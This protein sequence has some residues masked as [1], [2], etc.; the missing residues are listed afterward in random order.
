[1]EQ[2][3]AMLEADSSSSS[4][5]DSSSSDSSDSSDNDSVADHHRRPTTHRRRSPSLSRHQHTMVHTRLHT[6]LQCTLPPLEPELEQQLK[7]KLCLRV[8]HPLWLLQPQ[9][10]GKRITL[11]RS[12]RQPPRGL[13]MAPNIPNLKLLLRQTPGTAGV[14]L[15]LMM[16]YYSYTS[17]IS[18]F[19]STLFIDIQTWRSRL[20]WCGWHDSSPLSVWFFLFLSYVSNRNLSKIE[21][22]GGCWVKEHLAKS[23]RPSTLK[24]IPGRPLRLFVLFQN[25]G[26]QAELKYGCQCLGRSKPYPH[27]LKRS[28][29]MS[30]TCRIISQDV[31]R[32]CMTRRDEMKMYVV[33]EGTGYG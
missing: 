12:V 7:L 18:L 15:L 28:L 17:L 29:L 24:P 23:S 33:E 32:P 1:M 11:K 13:Y 25:I 20:L 21:L 27:A 2:R 9:R 5:S 22:S 19:D 3:R 4:D 6:N 8:P 31:M 30:W 16:Y 10:N 14:T 26:T